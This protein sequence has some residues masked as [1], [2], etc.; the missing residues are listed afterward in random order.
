MI[1]ENGTPQP[2]AAAAG[3]LRPVIIGAV[4]VLAVAIGAVLGTL[5]VSGQGA[6]LS[7][8]A[9]Y[10]PED[11]VM[12]AEVR[13]DLPGQQRANLRA[14]LDRFPAVN[15]D[16]ILTD[17]L[18]ETL[19]SALADGGAPI[20]YSSDIAPWFDG[21]AAFALFDY[22]A[23]TDPTQMQIPDFV[24]L[25]GVRDPAAAT[26]LADTLR[27]ELEAEG[28]VFT[29]AD[30]NGITVWSLDVEATAKAET[31]VTEFVG[32]VYTETT[33]PM[34]GMGFAYAVADD[35]LVMGNGSTAVVSALDTE[36]GGGGLSTASDIEPLLSALPAERAGVS[37]VNSAAMMAQMR[38]QLEAAQPEMAAALAQYLDAVPPVSVG[39]VS[40][41]ADAVLFDGISDVP[42]GPL[43]P[44]NGTRDLAAMVPA[45]A[46]L[47]ADSGNLG[48][49]LEQGVAAMKAA[50]AVAQGDGDQGLPGL[51][52]VEAGLGADLEELV[53]WIGAGA[54]AAGWDGEQPYLGFVLEALDPAAAERRL[55]QLRAL[56]EL[57]ASDPG[58][59]LQVSSETVAGAEVVTIRVASPDMTAFGLPFEA[60]LQYAVAGDQV[61][62]GLGDRFV[63]SALTMAEADSLAASQ[64]Y[65]AAVQRFGGAD[66]STAFFL[67]LDA[68]R[69]AGEEAIGTD[70][71]PMYELVRPNLMPFDY[72]AGVTRV[73]GGRVVSRMGLVLR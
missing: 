13:L 9:D 2:A 20:D 40:F 38:A 60:T 8:A 37:V 27:A 25:F 50:L 35:Q 17:T 56:A 3:R 29:S 52:Q 66:G 16:D 64:R 47:F 53:S 72:L 28:S 5:V 73:E 32:G 30:H 44:A 59:G 65:A 10:V 18:A 69:Q 7:R 55:G 12:Y 26:A 6:S 51:D 68:L 49:S 42:D 24:A 11:A 15:A 67:D 45:D 43:A 22:P 21:T 1:I 58:T 63:G 34:P 48:A 4:V 62:I 54:V 57:A 61:L 23:A 14:I 31:L 46:I 39:S 36:S 41:V 19:D 33:V 70:A 71:E